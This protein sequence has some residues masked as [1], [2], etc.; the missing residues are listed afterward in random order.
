MARALIVGCGCRGRLLGRRLADGGWQVR[1]TSRTESGAEEITRAGLDGAVADPAA[2]ASVLDQIGDVTLLFWLLGSATGEPRELDAIHG[3]GLAR[4]FEE[5]VDTPV[6]GF[7]YEAAG[8]VGAGLLEQGLTI[9]E[10]AARTWRIPIATPATDP[11]DHEAW[12]E[13]MLA[14]SRRLLA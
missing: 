12:L 11:A 4:L 3:S 6:R 1:G 2:I 10:E 7:V 5:I 13:A 14:A 8:S 9:V